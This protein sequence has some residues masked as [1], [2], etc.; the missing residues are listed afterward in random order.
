MMRLRTLLSVG[1]K[2]S[3]QVAPTKGRPCGA[4]MLRW[5][6]SVA[7]VI[8]FVKNQNKIREL[9]F[10]HQSTMLGHI[11]AYCWM[12]PWK[13]KRQC[14]GCPWPC[15]EDRCRHCIQRYT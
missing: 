15:D 2:Q 11:E 9:P 13:R 4:I 12:L 1:C 6:R 14:R 7:A 5:E 3:G 8:N 10:P